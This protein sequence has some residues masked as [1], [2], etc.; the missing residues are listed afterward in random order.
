[1]MDLSLLSKHY[2]VRKLNNSDADAVLRLCMENT[3]FYEYCEARPTKEQVLNDMSITPPGISVQDKYYI[4]FFQDD[5][6]IAVM[7]LIDGYPK[8]DVAFIGFFMMKKALQGRRIGS[9]VI[10][11]C[12]AY[13]KTVGISAIRLGSD[14]AN[15]Q[16]T[17]FWK[18]N[19]FSVI[20]EIDRDG[21][22]VL[23]A[24]KTL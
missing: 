1:M 2:A 8:P 6:L 23:L 20:K 4:G 21:W 3:Q 15:P 19:G 14:K 24:E 12:A 9:S 5:D 13:L 11:E 16:S 18:K 22:T 17:N 7:D 10:K